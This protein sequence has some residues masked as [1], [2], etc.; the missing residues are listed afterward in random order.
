VLPALVA[1]PPLAA[2]AP[3][4]RVLVFA[5]EFRF[6]LSRRSFRAGRLRLQLKNIGE[7]DHDLR[8]LGPTGRVRARTGVVASDDLAEIRVRLS[9]G[10]YRFY[11]SLGDHATRGMKGTFKVLPPKRRRA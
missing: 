2:T 4:A 1:H 3:P 5:D 6:S 7:D 11:C 8:I 10:R 9:R